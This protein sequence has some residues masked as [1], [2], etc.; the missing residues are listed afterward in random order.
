MIDW[1]LICSEARLTGGFSYEDYMGYMAVPI[2][3]A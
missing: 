1:Y 2:W 3:I